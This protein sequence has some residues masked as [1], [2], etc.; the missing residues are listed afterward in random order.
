MDVESLF[1][2]KFVNLSIIYKELASNI[3]F[4]DVFE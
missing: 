4:N 2:Q 3:E 1:T